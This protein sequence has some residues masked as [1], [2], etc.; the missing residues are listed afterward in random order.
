MRDWADHPTTRRENRSMT[1]H[2]YAI[3]DDV[4]AM[5]AAS[6]MEDAEEW[7]IH[8]Y[9]GFEGA[10]LSEYEGFAEVSELA[11]FIAEHGEIGGQLVNNLGSL[12]DAKKAIEDAYA[13]E[14]KS[15]ADFAEELAEQGTEIPEKL[16]FYIDYEAMARDLEINDVFTIE[17]SFEEMHVFWSY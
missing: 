6:P 16:R 7:A 17:I 15:L 11:A 9:E 2:K 12:D 5:L 14:C 1:T 3:Y 4:R 10:Q 8:D 13:G